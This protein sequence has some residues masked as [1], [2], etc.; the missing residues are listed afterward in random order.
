MRQTIARTDV[1]IMNY[2]LQAK[3]IYL[4][5]AEAT[6]HQTQWLP[7]TFILCAGHIL[8]YRLTT[9]ILYV[10]TLKKSNIIHTIRPFNNK[11]RS[12]HMGGQKV[13][14]SCLILSLALLVLAGQLAGVRAQE[15]NT[16]GNS[17]DSGRINNEPLRG[18]MIN[19]TITVVG[20]DFYNSFSKIWQALYPDSKNTLAVIERPTAKFGSEIWVSY[21]S[22]YVFHTFLSP[23]RSR[24]RDE[25]K[26]A[27]E[28]VR[29]NVAEIDL[30]RKLF[31]DADLGPQE[32]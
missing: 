32:M 20:W 30:R 29:K 7:N 12:L 27:V 25:S 4:L 31:Q 15:P 6:P 26:Q 17:L 8:E 11:L 9:S 19:R 22:Q 14:R 13:F 23:A 16:P 5:H 2:S 24:S 3:A 21:E 1:S 10:S 18:L 28:I